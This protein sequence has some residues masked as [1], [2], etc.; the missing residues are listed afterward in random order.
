MIEVETLS[1]DAFLQ[2]LAEL[3]AA[4]RVVLRMECGG[5]NGTYEFVHVAA[6]ELFPARPVEQPELFGE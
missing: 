1:G 5:R 4:S 6:A 2:R 3:K